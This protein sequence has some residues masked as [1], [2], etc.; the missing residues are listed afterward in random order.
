MKITRIECL[1]TTFPMAKPFMVS[2]PLVTHI[3]S[4]LIK[5]H[6]DEGIIGIGETGDTSVWHIGESWF[7]P[8]EV[9]SRGGYR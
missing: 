9:E 4:I 5:V 7:S 1:P 3:N 2:G 8:C 6:T